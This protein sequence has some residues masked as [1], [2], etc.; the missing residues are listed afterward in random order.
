MTSCL[1]YLNQVLWI[2][3]LFVIEM[4]YFRPLLFFY[5]KCFYTCNLTSYRY[6]KTRKC[7][8]DRYHFISLKSFFAEIQP[9]IFQCF[10]NQNCW[11][12]RSCNRPFLLL[13]ASFYR[14]CAL[15][16]SCS[17]YTL[18]LNRLAEAALE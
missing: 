15:R 12:R 16:R 8:L 14:T 5:L 9:C 17:I 4:I 3:N 11:Y 1:N 7:W 13:T 2:N 10:Q 18:V 6:R